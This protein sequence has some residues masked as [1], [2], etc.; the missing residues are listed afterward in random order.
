MSVNIVQWFDTQK[1]TENIFF[2]F[3]YGALSHYG[4]AMMHYCLTHMKKIIFQWKP[5]P[6][7]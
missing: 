6:Y 3:S 1:K 2:R 5:K 4:L 7:C